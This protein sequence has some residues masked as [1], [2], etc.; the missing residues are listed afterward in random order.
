MLFTKEQSD[1][2]RES[3][4]KFDK[5]IDGTGIDEGT[6]NCALCKKY[7]IE[8]PPESI[9]WTLT[10]SCI[11]CPVAQITD[12]PYCRHTPYEYIRFPN[13]KIYNSILYKMERAFLR[14]VLEETILFRKFE[15]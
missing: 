12:A 10:N 5:I 1:L 3:I 14:D 6:S 15:I 11:G 7:Y 9:E 13:S 4:T 8:T 2:T